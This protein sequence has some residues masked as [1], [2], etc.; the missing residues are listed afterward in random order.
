MWCAVENATRLASVN[1]GGEQASVP[2]TEPGYI[3]IVEDHEAVAQALA[4]LLQEDGHRSEIAFSGQEA[5]RTVEYA[6]PELILLDLNLPDT[7]GLT[8]CRQLKQH[9][10][11]RLIP[12][13]IVTA[14]ADRQAQLLS[15]AAGA[16]GYLQ[17]PVDAQELAT[18]VTALLRAKRLNDQLEPAENVIFALALTVEAKDAYTEGHLERLANYATAIGERI[19]ITGPALTALRYGAHLHDVGKIGIDETILRK[20]GALTAD[21]YRIMQQHTV[22]GERIVSPLRMA[23]RVGPIVRSHH[24][25]WNG[26]GYP[27]R[28]AGEAIPLGARIVAVVDAFDAMTTQRPYNRVFSFSEAATRLQ[29]GAGTIWDPAVVSVFIEWLVEQKLTA[30]R[31]QSVGTR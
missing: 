11:T 16:E 31:A 10:T 12:V 27:D 2:A 15:I 5:L 22:I 9:E 25:R 7:D 8:L 26:S 6:P 19:G 1:T 14:H 21:E 30:A 29:R 24:E 17:K 3:L 18:R 13:I 23:S 20:A 28:L 4:D